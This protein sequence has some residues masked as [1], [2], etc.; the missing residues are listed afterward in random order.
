MRCPYCKKEAGRIFKGVIAFCSKC[1]KQLTRHD[2]ATNINYVKCQ[3]CGYEPVPNNG[4]L[5]TFC[6]RCKKLTF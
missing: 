6:P 2:K 1:N 4:R 3:F 5:K